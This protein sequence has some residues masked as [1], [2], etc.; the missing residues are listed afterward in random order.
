[1][2][3]ILM[4]LLLL[5]LCGPA[6][7][8][9]G[10][11]EINQ[12]CALATGCFPGDAAGFP[13][14]ISAPGSYR[15]TS[16]LDV[17]ADADLDGIELATDGVTIDLN[18]FTVAGPV[19]CTG[20][21]SAVNCAPAGSGIGIDGTDRA[22]VTVNDGRLRGFA[23]EG[24]RV[25]GAAQISNVVV[26][27]NGQSGIIAGAR[28][29]VSESTAYRNGVTGIVATRSVV[30][31]SVASANALDG[32]FGVDGSSLVGNAAFGN[33]RHGINS[34]SGCVL[35]ENSAYQN[36]ESGIAASG[37]SVASDNAA[38]QNNGSG[39]SGF[40][41]HVQGNT[42]STN[43]GFGLVNSGSYRENTIGNNS[44]GTVQGG[45][46]AGANVCNGTTT[47]P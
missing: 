7:A 5:A 28:S 14:I 30:E 37:G 29:M 9:D 3:S 47:C 15:L 44:M 20:L 23:S 10:V 45:V 16:N 38:H 6:Y 27:S 4:L 21:G 31:R 32:I 46:D 19:T 22:R 41:S 1:M 2:R 36:E 25:S 24:I 34:Q 43:G 42:A 12:T 18:G 11:F 33:G 40:G 39:I 17:S 13:V 35:R 26:E 8:A